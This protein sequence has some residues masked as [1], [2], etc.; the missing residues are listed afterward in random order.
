M[1]RQFTTII[2][3]FLFPPSTRKRNKGFTRKKYFCNLA[4]HVSDVWP[5]STTYIWECQAKLADFLGKKM[6]FMVQTWAE[7]DS[8]NNHTIYHTTKIFTRLVG[9]IATGGY[10]A[11]T[12]GICHHHS[13]L[14]GRSNHKIW[15]ADL[16]WSPLLF[17][18]Q[19]KFSTLPVVLLILR[20][21]FFRIK[22]NLL[23]LKELA[24]V[25]GKQVFSNLRFCRYAW[26]HQFVR[27]L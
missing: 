6:I 15:H 17:N 4:A 19:W 9:D 16:L 18:F 10:L 25:F 23:H 11:V 26:V 7:K 13:W 5:P 22:T 8:L 12:K 24:M 21:T 2:G 27:L 14:V 1:S 3:T 20:P